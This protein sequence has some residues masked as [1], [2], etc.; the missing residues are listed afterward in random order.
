MQT[1]L[2]KKSV[3]RKGLKNSNSSTSTKNSTTNNHNL[4]YYDNQHDPDEPILTYSPPS[5]PSRRLKKI[6]FSFRTRSSPKRSLLQHHESIDSSYNMTSALNKQEQNLSP[7]RGSLFDLADH[8]IYGMSVDVMN[9][10]DN[11]DEY[12][13]IN[14]NTN[15]NT[16]TANDAR[17]KDSKNDKEEILDVYS[18]ACNNDSLDY[19]DPIA[20]LQP[21]KHLNI[22]DDDDSDHDMD[23]DIFKKRK[24][25]D[26][27]DSDNDSYDD[28]EIIQIAQFEPIADSHLKQFSPPALYYDF[29]DDEY[30]SDKNDKNGD[31]NDNHTNND[32]SYDG[33]V[34]TPRIQ[35]IT[36]NQGDDN[37]DTATTTATATTTTIQKHD[38]NPTKPTLTATATATSSSATTSNFRNTITSPDEVHALNKKKRL[39]F[40]AS[41]RRISS[42]ITSH[43]NNFTT[44]TTNSNS[45]VNP[46][47]TTTTTTQLESTFLSPIKPL[48]S[49]SPTILPNNHNKTMPNSSPPILLP[50]KMESLR[51]SI[52]TRTTTS[53]GLVGNTGSSVFSFSP[54]NNSMIH[55]DDDNDDDNNNND[56]DGNLNNID[57]SVESIGEILGNNN[58]EVKAISENDNDGGGGVVL[59]DSQEHS[60]D[61]DVLYMKQQQEEEESPFPD[62]PF[63]DLPTDFH[64]NDNN[65]EIID[66]NNNDNGDMSNQDDNDINEELPSSDIY[67]NKD[68]E[69]EAGEGER[70]IKSLSQDALIDKT[71]LSNNESLPTSPVESPRFE[72]KSHP[73]SV[74]VKLNNT[75]QQSIS[76][77]IGESTELLTNLNILPISEFV[78]L[79]DAERIQ[80]YRTLMDSSAETIAEIDE[81]RTEIFSMGRQVD[82]LSRRVSDLMETKFESHQKMQK[83][84]KDIE[85]LRSKL[86]SSDERVI[87][88]VTEIEAKDVIIDALKESIDQ[89]TSSKHFRSRSLQI[90]LA[91]EIE[92]DTRN[93][94]LK[95]VDSRSPHEKSVMERVREFE[96]DRFADRLEQ[97]KF[98]RREKDELSG[99]VKDLCI[100]LEA[101]D[102]IID[103]LKVSLEKYTSPRALSL[104]RNAKDDLIEALRRQ[105]QQKDEQLKEIN[106]ELASLQVQQPDESSADMKFENK[107]DE[108]V[109]IENTKLLLQVK[110]LLSQ[111]NEKE[112][113]ISDLRN[114]NESLV[115]ANEDIEE[116]DEINSSKNEQLEK[117]HSEIEEKDEAL[118]EITKELNLLK[119]KVSN[120][121]TSNSEYQQSLENLQSEIE[122]KDDA[123]RRLTNELD[124]LKEKAAN[125]QSSN[126]GHGQSLAQLQS[127]FEDLLKEKAAN[128][129]TSNSETSQS[130]EQLLAE[131]EEKDEALEKLTNE[132]DM[133]KEKDA[134]KTEFYQ[135]EL[136]SVQ[137]KFVHNKI[138]E[139]ERANIENDELTE[140]LKEF[141]SICIQ[142]DKLI[143]QV[144]KLEEECKENENLKKQLQILDETISEKDKLSERIKEFDKIC[145]EKEQLAKRVNELEVE[146]SDVSGLLEETFKSVKQL[147]ESSSSQGFNL[148]EQIQHLGP[149]GRGN[150]LFRKSP[151]R[152]MNNGNN[153]P[154]LT[155][156]QQLQR[157]CIIH[158]QTVLRQ[159]AEIDKLQEILNEKDTQLNEL[160]IQATVDQ[161][162]IT[163]LETQFIELNQSPKDIQETSETLEGNEGAINVD[164]AYIESL[165]AQSE[166]DADIIQEF[167][168]QVSVLKSRNE[169]LNEKIGLENDL[170]HEIEDLKTKLQ[171]CNLIIEG[172]EKSYHDHNHAL[173]NKLARD[174]EISEQSEDVNSHTIKGAPILSLNKVMVSQELQSASIRRLHDLV[175]KLADKNVG[176]KAELSS[177]SIHRE[178]DGSDSSANTSIIISLSDK[179]SLLHEYLKVSLH[180]LECK[181]SNDVESLSSVSSIKAE[182]DVAVSARFE[183]ALESMKEIENEMRCNLDVFEK[184]VRH[185]NIKISA[186]DGVI[187]NLLKT[188]E[189][190]N[191]KIKDLQVELDVFKSLSTYSSV[192]SGVM[193]RFQD[194]FRLEKELNHKEDEIKRLS[195][196]IRG[197]SSVSDA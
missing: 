57:Y 120:E 50:H 44:T 77:S 193:A 91:V 93:N 74:H 126:D 22:H 141:E 122:E 45:N 134:K 177:S 167:K 84:K 181:L 129:Q 175:G 127:E 9:D 4:N 32:N 160:R 86:S 87:S 85:E 68:E 72:N 165:Q 168:N 82:E 43:K 190:L 158:Q 37:N 172:L 138:K 105:L 41:Q 13:N 64:N 135:N 95:V 145:L 180:L 94:A 62:D 171:G 39:E 34:E 47:T 146:I 14:T 89:H 70:M 69:G 155:K 154:G 63:A 184:E 109:L 20:K 16:T 130:L 118:E 183:Q 49:T 96:R 125:N 194:S 51:S 113:T 97:M 123:L 19:N 186:K 25:R 75:D 103:E 18:Y 33:S 60:Y 197:K 185:Q 5:S 8:K 28:G 147:N 187:E 79:N 133:M 143:E 178:P 35:N 188:D 48:A 81:K 159:K 169:K 6:G 140:K 36:N 182:T 104:Q 23:I 76:S 55:D 42:S 107:A 40:M 67:R 112:N 179:L 162:K 29:S 192:N 108:S 24:D 119:E 78:K 73:G 38:E 144:N 11:T 66:D 173:N 189:R 196:I 195:S 2:K 58:N 166:R 131:I 110:E 174:N 1:K 161:E 98:N 92:N 170:R 121:Q 10:Y 163:A 139:L 128:N 71:I 99:R 27:Q 164:K 115:S 124:L 136:K 30:D 149:S 21:L 65:V 152:A 7:L 83:Y 156:I 12:E 100:E 46:N 106:S 157:M 116:G 114:L 132:L 90:P 80:A 56:S 176:D 59:N 31:D 117:L 150:P 142:K 61:Q 26:D 102:S 88:L 191:E 111:L 53:A 151:A 3:L 153:E 148:S 15:T 52:G 17:G 101:K 137:E 54:W